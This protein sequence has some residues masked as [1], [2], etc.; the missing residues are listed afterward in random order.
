MATVNQYLDYTLS[1]LKS[2]LSEYREAIKARKLKGF[3]TSLQSGQNQ[4]AK[5]REELRELERTEIAILSALHSLDPDNWPNDPSNR[6][7][8]ADFSGATL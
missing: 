4:L 3:T 7:T 2:E 8:V 1:K 5:Q 6:T